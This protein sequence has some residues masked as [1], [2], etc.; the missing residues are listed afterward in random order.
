[1]LSLFELIAALLTATALFAWV[2]HVWLGLPTNIALLAMGLC[3]SLF[4]VGAE[5]FFPG[6]IPSDV[7][8]RAIHQVDFSET[9][10]HGMLAFLLFAG[11][12]NVDMSRLR[13]RAIVIGILATVGVVI[14]MII[15]AAGIW[16]AA[17]VLG[18]PLS[19]GWA[20]VFGA[21]VA[22]TDPVTVLSAL[23]EV[24]VP[25][26]LQTDMAG[27]ALFNDG[28]GVVLFTVMLQA[29]AG[30]GGEF[31]ISDVGRLVVV[32]AL[33][34]AA[35]ELVTGYIAYR[36]MLSIDEYTIEVL[37]SLALVTATYAIAM[38][39][40]TS[41][42]IAV[43][44]A[45]VLI[46]NHG[47]AYAMSD[48]TR[49]YVFGFWQLVDDILNAMLFLLIGLEVL[50]MSFKPSL[51]WIGLAAIP[52]AIVARLAAVSGPVYAL[53]HW[54]AFT[55]GM[56]PILTWG[57]VRGGISVALA[58]SLPDSPAR[59]LILAATYAIV[60]FTV[61]VQGMTLG[62]VVERTATRHLE[63]ERQR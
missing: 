47:S 25:Q 36:A 7:F 57:A 44:V 15:V 53:R 4:I 32:E 22:P 35:L 52:V 45:G 56:I 23:K 62:R 58:L 10:M 38:K 61:I 26:P 49:R 24:S 40:G 20:L 29:V 54:H 55:P 59:P 8:R 37:I 31:G 63:A 48:R 41:G 42:P 18:L 33:G 11:A 16:I 13:N 28:I 19:F 9:F 5:A 43:V 30:P 21:L 6:T 34:G 60:L 14:S 50:V 12:M 1:M 17:R 27:E 2:N 3:A 51:I 46:G 39:I